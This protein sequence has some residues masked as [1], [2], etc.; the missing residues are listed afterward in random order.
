M[1][2][3]VFIALLGFLAVTY[4]SSAQN[5]PR[6]QGLQVITKPAIQG[7]LE[8]L[9]SDWTNGRETGTKGAYMA[10]DYIIAS[11]YKLISLFQPVKQV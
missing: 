10:A 1:K 9:A 6:E 7:P 11:M 3:A 5:N 2:K 4:S 8:F